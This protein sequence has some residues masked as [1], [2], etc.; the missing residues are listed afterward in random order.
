MIFPSGS[1][2]FLKQW[3][4]PASD[5]TSLTLSST[6]LDPVTQ[7]PLASSSIYKLNFRICHTHAG[8]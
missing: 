5:F 1:S 4:H 3:L 2:H 6:L 7:N 8:R